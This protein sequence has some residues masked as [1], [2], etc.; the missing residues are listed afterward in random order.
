VTRWYFAH[1][2]SGA[3][4]VL[5]EHGFHVLLF[6]VGDEG[7]DRALLLDSR[8]LFKRVDAVLVLSL[9]LH[10]AERELLRRLKIPVVTVGVPD[11]DWPC[12]RIDDLATTSMATEHLISLGHCRI[13]YVGGDTVPSMNFPTP[14]DRASGFRETMAR[15]GL[16]VEPG[17]VVMGDWTAR[18]GL[19]VGRELLARSDRPTALVA[20]SDELA[21]G[22]LAAARELGLSVPRDVSVVGIDNHEM[23]E[24]YG[25]TTIAQPVDEQGR[26]ATRLLLS[27]VA[28]VDAGHD[29]ATVPIT[30]VERGSTAA[31]PTL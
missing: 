15:H 9:R 10:E 18:S 21:L 27:A 7:P 19:E 23:A 24:L 20:A 31:P 28:G 14:A 4:E 17:S 29:V 6:D 30:L 13:G 3:S 2:I 25:L 16:D 26:M 22:V 11:P 5:R 1:L 8:M 12:V